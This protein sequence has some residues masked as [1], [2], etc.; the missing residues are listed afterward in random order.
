MEHFTSKKKLFK[1]GC[2]YLRVWNDLRCHIGNYEGKLDPTVFEKV[3]SSCTSE[4]MQ[5]RCCVRIFWGFWCL[6]KTKFPPVPDKKMWR[7]LVGILRYRPRRQHQSSVR[8]LRSSWW[9]YINICIWH[10]HVFF[11]AYDIMISWYH[12]N[13]SGA[14]FDK[15]FSNGTERSQITS[16]SIQGAQMMSELPFFTQAYQQHIFEVHGCAQNV[17]WPAPKVAETYPNDFVGI[18]RDSPLCMYILYM[19][20]YTCVYKH[21]CIYTSYPTLWG[22]ATLWR[23]WCTQKTFASSFKFLYIQRTYSWTCDISNI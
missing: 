12:S 18:W 7:L 4:S 16:W 23:G 14:I 8:H 10:M 5:L 1:L 17:R 21:M 22:R 20:T 11:F 19:H 15:H 9:L 3:L 6:A 2:N 13:L